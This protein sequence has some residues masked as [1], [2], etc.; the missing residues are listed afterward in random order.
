MVVRDAL[1]ITQSRWRE[2]ASSR[3][4]LID[5]CTQDGPDGFAYTS[6]D[7][8][9]LREDPAGLVEAVAVSALRRWFVPR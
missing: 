1:D 6:P 5:V 4:L 2:E 8:G 9:P 7:G 3:G